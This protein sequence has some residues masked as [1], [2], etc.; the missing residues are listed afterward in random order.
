[1]K[2]SAMFFIITGLLVMLASL[3]YTIYK[4]MFSGSEE[5][6]ILL[7]KRTWMLGPA[8]TAKSRKKV[9]VVPV[10]LSTRM[11]PIRAFLDVDCIRS[12]S[13]KVKFGYQVEMKDSNGKVLWKKEGT[14]SKSGSKEYRDVRVCQVLKTFDIGKDGDYYIRCSIS[15]KCGT[16]YDATLRL[17]SN[18]AKINWLILGSGF[19]LVLLGFS[20]ILADKTKGK[21]TGLSG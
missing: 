14:A 1:M 13:G 21:Y 17:K 2:N 20:L 5:L 9:N 15:Q 10:T 16:I 4:S 19:V 11:N 3:S 18:V 7:G 12:S 6:A 8:E